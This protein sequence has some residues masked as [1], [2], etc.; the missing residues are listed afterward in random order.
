MTYL[1]FQ[2]M[3]PSEEAC[4]EYIFRQKYDTECPCGGAFY[5]L[6][7]RRCYSCSR[8]RRQV[9]P[10]AGSPMHGS[11]TSLRKWFFAIYLFAHS[12][13]GVSAAELRR[14]LGVTGKTAWRMG[15]Q[16]RGM[17][18]QGSKKLNGIVEVDETYFGGRSKR[19][20][21]FKSKAVVFGMVQRNGLVRAHIIP[22]RETHVILNKIKKNVS[23]DAHIMSDEAK[24]YKKLHKIGYRNS[25]VKHGKRN[26]VRGNVYT[27]GVEG[28]WSQLKRG[29]KG[30]HVSVTRKYLQ[31]YVDAQVFSLN[32]RNAPRFE[33]LMKRL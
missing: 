19:A 22:N 13:H 31:A 25:R 10:F 6:R 5:R 11:R 3:F 16:I 7:K 20:Q 12:K 14:N 17:M 33:I 9:Y 15:R 23:K 4:L 32:Y 29:I 2:G 27:N 1:E 21:A 28:L 26:Y 24:V 18:G 30:T 8:C